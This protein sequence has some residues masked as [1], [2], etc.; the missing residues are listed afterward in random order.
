MEQTYGRIPVQGMLNHIP[1][2][3]SRTYE[4]TRNIDFAFLHRIGVREEFFML[5]GRVS[6]T[7][8]FWTIQDSCLAH[9]TVTIEF[10]SS[11]HLMVPKK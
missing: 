5:M 8:P 7:T 1:R 10:L 2:M 3:V 4:S 6:F 11:L 9:E